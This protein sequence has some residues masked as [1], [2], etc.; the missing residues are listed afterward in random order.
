ML[1]HSNFAL[2]KISANF[3]FQMLTTSLI[4]VPKSGIWTHVWTLWTLLSFDKQK[5]GL[6]TKWSKEASILLAW[7]KNST[8]SSY[9]IKIRLYCIKMWAPKVT[10]NYGP[11]YTSQL[12]FFNVIWEGT[13][14]TPNHQAKI[15]TTTIGGYK[16]Q[17]LT[18]HQFLSCAIVVTRRKWATLVHV[19]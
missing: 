5:V 4:R 8:S 2:K 16:Q 18:T 9:L 11:H 3:S 7:Q 12:R 19:H 14:F 1:D 6:I 17:P 10:I 15:A 13:F